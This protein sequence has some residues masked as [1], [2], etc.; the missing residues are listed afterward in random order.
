MKNE[1]IEIPS[2]G[3][4]IKEN[5]VNVIN[6]LFLATEDFLNRDVFILVSVSIKAL[7]DKAYIDNLINPEI[8]HKIRIKVTLDNMQAEVIEVKNY[9][10]K[11]D[12]IVRMERIERTAKI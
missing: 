12:I 2:F 5:V 1:I 7:C 10:E 4:I 6:S 8:Y 11:P 9:D 3:A